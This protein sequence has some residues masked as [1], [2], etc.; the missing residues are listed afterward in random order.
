MNQIS[1]VLFDLDGTLTDPAEGITACMRYALEKLSLPSRETP[2]L[3]SF[4]GPPIRE[5]FATLC[6]T[7]D[8]DLIERAIALY[9][10]RFT[11]AGLYENKVYPGVSEMLEKLR[12]AGCR[13]F[14]A[15]SKP[16]PFAER[17]LAH[18]SLDQYF[19]AIHGSELEGGRLDDKGVL[20]RELIERHR[21][22]PGSTAMVGDRKY[23]IMG[24][25]ANGLWAVGVAYG[26]GSREELLEAGAD[27][28]CD[29]P[30]D[31]ARYVEESEV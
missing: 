4:I 23:D 8:H 26:Y 27:H 14:V 16:Q 31:V 25:A 5:T 6:E 1:N 2:E 24:A 7:S 28:I 15:T 18:F 13:L 19:T 29:T 20:I 30:H 17:V 12:S 3:A 22:E 10:E 21:L 11:S 9:R